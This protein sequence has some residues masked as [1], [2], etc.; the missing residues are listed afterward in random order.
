MVLY[1]FEPTKQEY[2]QIFDLIHHR[3]SGNLIYSKWR[4]FHAFFYKKSGFT[5]NSSPQNVQ[6]TVY[7]L[8]KHMFDICV[9]LNVGVNPIGSLEKLEFATQELHQATVL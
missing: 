4:R 8:S 2:D 3:R 1:G 7:L 5:Q 9:P 6:T